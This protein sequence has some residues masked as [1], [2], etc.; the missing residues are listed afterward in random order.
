MGG[1]GRQFGEG[2]NF[3]VDMAC[4]PTKD[5]KLRMAPVR[6]SWEWELL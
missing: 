2:G 3:M 1:E 4:D 5:K 6:G